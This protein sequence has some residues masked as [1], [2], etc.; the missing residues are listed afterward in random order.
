ME[1]GPTALGI[2][3]RM[4]LIIAGKDNLS[5][6]IVGSTVLGIEPSSVEHLK[7]FACLTNRSPEINSIHMRGEDIKDVSRELEW[8][9]DP[10]DIFRRAKIRGI[11]S[12]FPGKHFCTGCVCHIEAIM[13]AFCKDNAGMDFDNIEIC[14]GREV[15][16]KKDSKK[17]FLVGNCSILANRAETH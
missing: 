9:F 5:C 17:V 16:H 6:D 3:H 1:R 10:A 11:S 15:K 4:N 8:E 14:A 12:Q 2:A 7:E 13:V